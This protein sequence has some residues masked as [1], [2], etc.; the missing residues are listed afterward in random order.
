MELLALEET[1]GYG[2]GW[3]CDKCS[4]Q[5]TTDPELPRSRHRFHC[6]TCCSDLCILC[7]RKLA[8]ETGQASLPELPLPKPSA[9]A[10][11]DQ[12]MNSPA[13]VNLNNGL[14][15][16]SVLMRSL[17]N[18]SMATD[19]SATPASNIHTPPPLGEID[20]PQ[21][22]SSAGGGGGGNG[23]N[24]WHAP[25]PIYAQR[26][27]SAPGWMSADR[28]GGNGA[29]ASSLPAHL[30]NQA[31]D[32]NLRSRQ[33][34]SEESSHAAWF[35]AA[36]HQWHTERE[37]T[38]DPHRTAVTKV[39]EEEYEDPGAATTATEVEVDVTTFNKAAAGHVV[40]VVKVQDVNTKASWT[41]LKR[42]TEFAGL[43]EI[44]ARGC[45]HSKAQDDLKVLPPF[46]KKA[47]FPDLN[48]RRS[49]LHDWI[50]DVVAKVSLQVC[51]DESSRAAAAFLGLKASAY[52]APAEAFRPMSQ[53]MPQKKEPPQPRFHLPHQA[54]PI[55]INR[56]PR[57]AV[58]G[59]D[60]ATGAASA[61][62]G[63]A[64]GFQF[65][66]WAS[67]NGNTPE[68]PPGPPGTPA[69][70]SVSMAA[71]IQTPSGTPPSN[72]GGLQRMKIA[73][74]LAPAQKELERVKPVSVTD[75]LREAKLLY[76]EGLIGASDY[77]FAKEQFIDEI[78]RS[79]D[80]VIQK[81][82]IGKR[83]LTDALI[84]DAEYGA[85]KMQV[86]AFSGNGGPGGALLLDGSNR[87]LASGS[88]YTDAG[89]IASGSTSIRSAPGAGGSRY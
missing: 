32:S 71:A 61:A 75:R 89:S 80:E 84:D 63:D 65:L 51:D 30:S 16:S 55:Q 56:A 1:P 60:N 10:G 8:R 79:D 70:R 68:D 33:R 17:H 83:A 74:A 15:G 66:G 11:M 52:L 44:I 46:P 3:G 62:E 50:Q 77:R 64:D 38:S 40:Y 18:E 58:P 36:K 48:A 76:T 87:S 54:S 42:Y 31:L 7:G 6:K 12:T 78:A 86:L 25:K 35:A 26:R 82:R 69:R 85:I 72:L 37:K 49:M 41:M 24:G 2:V 9:L 67:S 57:G 28:D 43:Q 45:K 39:A 81:L 34:P 4:F 88:A 21:A 19:A 53:P 29:I 13:G 14:N 5:S 22:T 59:I 47:M 73:P 20:F 27:T 23:G